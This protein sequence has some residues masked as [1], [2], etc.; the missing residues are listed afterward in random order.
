MLKCFCGRG[1]CDASLSDVSISGVF[2]VAGGALC[3]GFLIVF[4]LGY[5]SLVFQ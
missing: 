4:G 3:F 5:W 1:R 2:C